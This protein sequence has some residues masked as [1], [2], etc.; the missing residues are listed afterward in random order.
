[1]EEITVTQE[2]KNA[3]TSIIENEK[4]ATIPMEDIWR[5]NAV[6]PASVQECVRHLISKRAHLEPNAPAA[7]VS[8]G[9]ND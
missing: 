4:K 8:D 1:M 9:K 2:S 6:V 5:W 7:Y 3:P